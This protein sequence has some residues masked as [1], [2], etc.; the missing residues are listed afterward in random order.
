MSIEIS[1][2]SI[3]DLIIVIL[4]SIELLDNSIMHVSP[5]IDNN[6][7]NSIHFF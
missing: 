3:Y 6:L 4:K 7:Y 1:T 5:K 2:F